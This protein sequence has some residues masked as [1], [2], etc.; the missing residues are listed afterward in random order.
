MVD[1]VAPPILPSINI[2]TT[3]NIPR[4]TLDL[5]SAE[6][7]RYIPM[8]V[9]PSDLDRP[10]GVKG[11]SEEKETKTEQPEIP[12][13][14]IPFINMEVPLPT[15][16]VVTTATYAAVSAVAVTTLAQPFF[17]Q[18]KKKIQKFLQGKIDKWKK[19]KKK[20]VS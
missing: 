4:V 12:K 10:E 13:I 15:A 1:N 18:I 17:D 7:P 2:P 8:V 19:N 11:D 6:I 20:K 5:P 14:E 9:P 16:E 3:P